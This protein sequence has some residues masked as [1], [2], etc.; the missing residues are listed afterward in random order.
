MR[1]VRKHVG[2]G[3]ERV[4]VWADQYDF[5]RPDLATGLRQPIIPRPPPSC[6]SPTISLTAVDFGLR[7]TSTNHVCCLMNPKKQVRMKGE[8]LLIFLS[9]LQ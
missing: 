8:N 7:T 4:M 9:G 2:P 3:H 5:S 6:C 1:S